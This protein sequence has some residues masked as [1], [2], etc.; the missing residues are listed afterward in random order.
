M[1]ERTLF[2]ACV[3]VATASGQL[4][5]EPPATVQS[6]GMPADVSLQHDT[7]VY[8][9][10]PYLRFVAVP[11]GTVAVTR[12][13]AT[14]QCGP[15]LA[16][17]H[18]WTPYRIRVSATNTTVRITPPASY[19]GNRIARGLRWY[20]CTQGTHVAVSGATVTTLHVPLGAP[21]TTDVLAAP[22]CDDINSSVAVADRDCFVCSATAK[23][24]SCAGEIG[25]AYDIFAAVVVCVFLAAANLVGL[26]SL[27]RTSSNADKSADGSSIVQTQF[28]FYVGHDA[29]VATLQLVG[30]TFAFAHS[31]D[32]LARWDWNN[33]N[34]GVS[35]ACAGASIF[36]A[37]IC[38]A[39]WVKAPAAHL[40]VHTALSFL[41]VLFTY[42]AVEAR[43]PGTTITSVSLALLLVYASFTPLVP[44]RGSRA[45][46]AI[47]LAAD[48]ASIIGVSLYALPFW[49]EECA[50]RPR[51][52]E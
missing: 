50:D 33:T 40:V 23:G 44:L 15:G 29:T 20:N 49:G 52:T 9:I 37:F 6:I 14:Q 11:Y 42:F 8:Y 19:D 51:F 12:D 25:D 21:P 34:A 39:G 47:G 16:A 31:L 24:C 28:Y 35:V 43:R 7:A 22:P 32:A 10:Q 3:L 48:V 2:L 26:V 30:Y 27:I 45:L 18:R 46:S 4:T 41:F 17:T 36:L 38:F 13:E 1:T 5:S